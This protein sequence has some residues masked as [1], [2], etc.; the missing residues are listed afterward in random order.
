MSGLVEERSA[1]YSIL[2]SELVDTL[3]R[4]R[5]EDLTERTGWKGRLDYGDLVANY[6][7]S[8]D[9]NLEIVELGEYRPGEGD[10]NEDFVPEAVIVNEG[11]S[12]R[13]KRVY[14]EELEFLQGPTDGD[15]KVRMADEEEI[16]VFEDL[17]EP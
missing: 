16:T 1:E 6:K 17:L 13:I 4:S 2:P 9:G 8:D 5:N 10:W 3:N 12:S 14:S 11:G 15:H 7:R